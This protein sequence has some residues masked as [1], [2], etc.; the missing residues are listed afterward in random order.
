[1]D[2]EDSIA[3]LPTNSDTTEEFLS[4]TTDELESTMAPA[5]VDS[6]LLLGTANFCLTTDDPSVVKKFNV[7]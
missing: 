1:M 4:E 2:F 7:T 3:P 5:V 6:V